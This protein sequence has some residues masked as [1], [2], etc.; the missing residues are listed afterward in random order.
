MKKHLLNKHSK[1]FVK[2]KTWSKP[3]KGSKKKSKKWNVIHPLAI[4]KYFNGH[5][6]YTKR[7]PFQMKFIEDLVLYNITKGYEVFSSIKLP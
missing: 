2:Y 4:T 5:Q 1:D 6:G 7:D 3:V